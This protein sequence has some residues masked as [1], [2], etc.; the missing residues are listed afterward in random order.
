LATAVLTSTMLPSEPP[1]S[2]ASPPAAVVGSAGSRLES[3]R[4]RSG[5]CVRTASGSGPAPG[6]W[7][8]LELGLGLGLGLG[9]G[10]GVGVG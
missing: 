5:S 2:E 4:E 8:G 7:L 10:V 9:V 3:W 6:T 1:A